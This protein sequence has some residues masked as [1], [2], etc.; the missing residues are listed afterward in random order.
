MYTYLHTLSLHA[1]LPISAQAEADV[2]EHAHHQHRHDRDQQQHGQQGDALLP[3]PLQGEGRDGDGFALLH[4]RVPG[5]RNS[6]SMRPSPASCSSS[7]TASGIRSEEH[8]S[9]LQSLMRITYAVFC[10]TKKQ[11]DTTRLD[12]THQYT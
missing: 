6:C 11:Q 10:L 8:T 12:F 7:R 2:V 1:A 4:V 3:L 5:S 9:E